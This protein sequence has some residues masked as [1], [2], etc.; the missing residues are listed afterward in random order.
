[1]LR[2][3]QNAGCVKYVLPTALETQQAQKQASISANPRPSSTPTQKHLAFTSFFIQ[4]THYFTHAQKN[5]ESLFITTHILRYR[6]L[7][8]T[9]R[10]RSYTQVHHFTQSLHSLTT[11]TM[12]AIISTLY[13]V[14]S[15]VIGTLLGFLSLGFVAIMISG[16]EFAGVR[17]ALRRRGV[18]LIWEVV[19]AAEWW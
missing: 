18:V 12:S 3:R 13:L 7:L 1:M 16:P 19:R 2:D 11:Q 6:L 14:A 8:P 17:A 15:I 10:S 4:S 5:P 9:L